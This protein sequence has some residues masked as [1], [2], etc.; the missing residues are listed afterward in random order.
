[1]KDHR[2]AIYNPPGDQSYKGDK[3]WVWT[4][5][6][7]KDLFPKIERDHH[8]YSNHLAIRFADP[9]HPCA[10]G[11][12]NYAPY[13]TAIKDVIRFVVPEYTVA[14]RTFKDIDRA[15]VH[16]TKIAMSENRHVPVEIQDR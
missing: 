7:F 3:I 13:Y 8:L 4:G 10:K 15:I 14:G 5:G 12:P 2:L 9:N 1:M 16:A 6:V 11:H